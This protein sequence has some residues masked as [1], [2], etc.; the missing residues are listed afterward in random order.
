MLG[1]A[2]ERRLLSYPSIWEGLR[3][4]LVVAKPRTKPGRSR[5]DDRAIFGE[6][7]WLARTGAQWETLP[8]RFGSTSTVHDRVQE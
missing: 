2:L 3:P 8:R 7:I 4:L 5:R 6:L 1:F